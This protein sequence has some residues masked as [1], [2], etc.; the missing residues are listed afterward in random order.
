MIIT[1]NHPI[2]LNLGTDLAIGKTYQLSGIL[3][4]VTD[5]DFSSYEIHIVNPLHQWRKS[6]KR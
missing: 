3:Y 2:I 5:Y 4:E 1:K 6:K